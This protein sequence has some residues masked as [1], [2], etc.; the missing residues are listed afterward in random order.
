MDHFISERL[1]IVINND[2]GPR[3]AEE[4]YAAPYLPWPAR[5]RNLQAKALIAERVAGLANDGDVI[6]VGSGSSAYLALRAI[7]RRAMTTGLSIK[8]IPSS[9]ETEIAAATMGIAMA[10]LRS[11]QPT[12]IVDG[13]DEVDGEGRV[14]K[15]RGGALFREKLLW[16]QPAKIYLVIDR[17]KRVDRLGTNFPVPVETHPDALGG[18][19]RYLRSRSEVRGFQL[20]LADGKDGPLITENG[21][22]IVDVYTNDLPHGFHC[23]L[24]AVPGVLETGIFEGYEFSTM[25]E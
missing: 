11:A 7:G 14:L 19:F 6:G 3:P 10:S 22:L 4:H 23:E 13:A 25:E 12:W 24:K 8:V 18:L 17:T 21:F 9:Y 20:R 15:G 1:A 2:Q 16:A 5:I